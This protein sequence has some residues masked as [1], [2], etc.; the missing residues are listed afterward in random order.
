[1]VLLDHDARRTD[2]VPGNRS[3]L[4]SGGG[5]HGVKNGGCETSDDISL[6]GSEQAVPISIPAADV[7]VASTVRLVMCFGI[8][9]TSCEKNILYIV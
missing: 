1:M 4:M 9:I 6:F 3:R 7:P 2:V 5:L 8:F